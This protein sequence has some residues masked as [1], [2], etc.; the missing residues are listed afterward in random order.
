MKKPL[1]TADKMVWL[2]ALFFCLP[3]MALL[4]QLFVS[5][6]AIWQH[7]TTT[8]LPTYLSQSLLLLAW[9]A[10]GT[11]LI[12]VSTAWLVA[13]HD[14]P[15]RT[16]FQ[17][18]LILPMAMP[19]YIVAY[20]YTWWLDVAG[21]IQTAL[22]SHF[23]W[24]FSDYYFPNIRSF[25]GAVVVLTLV[26][27]P[28]VY[29]L[30]RAA[31][32]KQTKTLSEVHQLSGGSTTSFFYRVALPLA[33]PAIFGGLALVMM[34]TL[35]DYGTVQYFG[36]NT[37]TTGILKT[38]FGL[39]SLS[40]AA[41][42][43]MLLLTMVIL[44]MLLEKVW[45]GQAKYD[46]ANN[47]GTTQLRSI[48]SSCKKW[49]AS[50]WCM[51]VVVL[52]FVLP[53]TLL[54]VMAFKSQIASWYHDFLSVTI[55]TLWLAGITALITVGAALVLMYVKRIHHGTSHRAVIQAMSLGYAIPGLVIAV[56][57][58]IAFGWLDQGFNS[59]R[60]MFSNASPVL[61]FSGGFL[62]L[63]TAY[64]MRF[65]AVAIQPIDAAYQSIRPH[66]DEAS[67]LTGKNSSQTF[68][69]IHMPLLKSSV[70]T[71]MLLVFVDLLKE[72]PATLVLRPFNF[73]TLAVK[74]YELASD[75]RLADAA[76]PALSIVAVGLIPVLLLNQ[77]INAAHDNHA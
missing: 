18:L 49:L 4:L 2:I 59:I 25:S 56:G 15:G 39:G 76:I 24:S 60:S 43:A 42:I 64:V 53:A 26:L 44:V 28:Y 27:Y 48:N 1:F 55:D 38:W 9:V 67:L 61:F 5:E 13:S 58:T 74:A 63:I 16:Y 46:T 34:E 71:A 66:L 6:A 77:R 35:A 8:V 54:V 65:L 7:L 11:L 40:G 3:F 21:P 32:Q 70:W 52:G 69:Q 36:V 41:Q 75:E 12:G 31:F 68:R 20:A 72:L 51:L 33:R 57:V 29:L 22:R 30:A 10:L 50:C 45:R 17:W 14:F 23:D 47:T 62:A 19:A 73:N 37:L